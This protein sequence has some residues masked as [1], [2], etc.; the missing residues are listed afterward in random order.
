MAAD[1][2]T[3]LANAEAWLGL[4][5]GVSQQV[6]ALVTRLIAA[7]SQTILGWLQRPS[8]LVDTYSET[9]DGSGTRKLMLRRWPVLSISSLSV[10]NVPIQAGSYSG[11]AGTSRA[12]YFYEAWDGIPPGRMTPLEL[13]GYSFRAGHQNVSIGYTAGYGI[14]DEPQTVAEVESAYQV[15]V[16]APYG[17]WAGDVGVTYAD[18]TALTRVDEAPAEAGQYQ[19]G[20]T[21]G[22][23]LFDSAD[24][25]ADVL[26]SYSFTP[27]GV[28][29]ACIEAVTDA[30]VRQSV[31]MGLGNVTAFKAGG[32]AVTLSGPA[33]QTASFLI[34]DA[35]TQ[36]LTPFKRVVPLR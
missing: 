9:R 2:L 30:Y 10:D 1:L 36:D 29:Q 19:L 4:T 26:V 23:Y 13:N 31:L 17:N 5:P 35:I 11:I 34:S 16:D 7:Q 27:A 12:G 28:E 24:N 3:T 6:D 18:G 15:T 22:V 33:K 32:S 21:P 20:T 25:D 8:L 14:T